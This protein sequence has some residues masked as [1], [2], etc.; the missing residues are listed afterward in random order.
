MA[1]LLIY[2]PSHMLLNTYGLRQI[3]HHVFQTVPRRSSLSI[4][5]LPPSDSAK[6]AD[7]PLTASYVL[8]AKHLPCYSK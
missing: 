8:L 1:M 2:L 3:A 6:F 4:A 7:L 5:Q